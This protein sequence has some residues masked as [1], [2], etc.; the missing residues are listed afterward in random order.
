MNCAKDFEHA[1]EAEL[2]QLLDWCGDCDWTAAQRTAWQFVQTGDWLVYGRY[3]RTFDWVDVS[4][5]RLG[6]ASTVGADEV[7]QAQ[8]AADYLADVYHIVE[9][10]EIEGQK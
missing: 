5:A 4:L 6:V 9:V 10:Y 7:G 2:R 1:V 3:G 8:S